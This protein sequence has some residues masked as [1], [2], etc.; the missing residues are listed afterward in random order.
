MRA[1]L[2][3]AV[4]LVSVALIL[5]A[6]VLAP[7][8]PARPG[9]DS[10]ALTIIAFL[11]P[12]SVFSGV[13][14]LIA[15]RQPRNLIG[16]LLIAVGFLFALVLAWSSTAY[17]GLRTGSIPK[18][19]A[20]WASAFYWTWVIALGLLGNQIP[21]RLPDGHLP[22]P[23]WRWYSRASIAVMVV[24]GIGMCLQPGPVEDV[25][26]TSNP[27]G[28]EWAEPL[29]FALLL[30]ILSFIGA[31]VSLF[32]RYRRASARARVQLRWIAFGGV[33]FLVIYVVTLLVPEV[34]GWDDRSTGTDVC[35]YVSQVAFAALPAAIGVA[36]LR[37]RLYDLGVVVN[38]ALVYAGLTATLAAAYLGTVLL[39]Q[40]VMQ[41]LT[42]QSDLAIAVSTLAVAALARPA[43]RRIQGIVDRRFYRSRYD[44]ALTLSGFG[45]RLREEV[46]LDNLSAEL[47]DVVADTMQPAHV[48]LWLRKAES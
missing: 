35:V 32:R 2:A 41:P 6:I 40:L 13:G 38:R 18:D 17:W 8:T 20:E 36:I 29:V 9:D 42:E 27:L 24:A 11:V 45:S 12:I 31:I 21:L 34:L 37:H 10:S 43:R 4:P 44:A 15:R 22:S 1:R 30:M 19:V 26:G 33:V 14:G 28:A 3:V 48:S 25:K 23:R 47:R 16:W 5:Y 46:D 39:L 7:S